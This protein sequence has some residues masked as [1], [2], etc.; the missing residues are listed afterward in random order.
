MIGG[1]VGMFAGALLPTSLWLE[2]S[3]I[4]LLYIFIRYLY[5][6]AWCFYMLEMS[7]DKS[8]VRLLL[9]TVQLC[10]YSCIIS[11]IFHLCH[12]VSAIL[13]LDQVIFEK[14]PMLA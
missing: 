10:Y 3:N 2:A 1:C 13:K 4:Q 9:Y 11:S 6:C 12:S 14:K 5:V 7:S 8:D